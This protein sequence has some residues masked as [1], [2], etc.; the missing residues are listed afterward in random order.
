M[1]DIYEVNYSPNSPIFRPDDM[2]H[3]EEILDNI[4]ARMHGPMRG[5]IKKYFN[6]FQHV[7]QDVS[8][9]YQ[10]AGRAAGSSVVPSTTPP[11]DLLEWFSS[12]IPRE[13]GRARGSWHIPSRNTAPKHAS[14]GDGTR[15]FLSIPA[16]PASDAQTRW[17]RVQVVGQVYSHGHVDYQQGLLQLCQ[18][19]FRVFISQPTRLFL[20]GFYIRGSLTELWVFDR[21]GLYCSDTIDVRKNFNEFSAAILSYQRMTDQELGKNKIMEIDEGSDG[22]LHSSITT[23]SL[24]KLYLESEPIASSQDLV[25]PGT[26]CYRAGIPGSNRWDYVVKFAWRWAR[27]RPEDELLKLAK[28][29]CV[30]GV[31][32]V[33]HYEELESTANL[34]RGLRWG[35]HKKFTR[36]PF[37][38]KHEAIEQEQRQEMNVGGF[39]HYT[40]ETDD[41]FRNRILAC[42]VTSPVGRP[43]STFRSVSELLRVFHD[44]IKCHRSLFHDAKILHQDIS[45]GNMIIVDSREETMLTGILI[46][47]DSAI[48][49]SSGAEIESSI[50]GTRPFMAIGVLKREQHTYRHDLESFL[51]VFLWAIITNHA[52]SPPETSRLRQWSNGGWDELAARKSLDMDRNNFQDLLTEFPPGLDSLKPLAENLRQILF[53][54]RD[55]AIWTK[56]D[57]SPDAVDKLYDEMLNAFGNFIA[58]EEGKIDVE[59][60]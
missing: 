41:N 54:I 36:L 37:R 15:I 21:S 39:N 13:T 29:K 14:V 49:I 30:W 46:D 10:A 8:P 24:G 55:G 1:D 44:A 16:S 19:A 57:S 31:V 56:T 6:D 59:H 60:I 58:S 7:H 20:H 18:S 42:I 22:I 43:L 32:S 34:R 3:D 23:P 28:E 52:S 35:P 5:F 38:E 27:E 48:E 2:P 9:E 50:I 4:D 51:Y 11:D 26:T 53:P 47:L 40:E 12:Y 25:G 33:D 45:P 17:D